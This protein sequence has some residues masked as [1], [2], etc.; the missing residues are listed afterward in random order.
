[1]GGVIEMFVIMLIVAGL[2]FA[3]L[4]YFIYMYTAKGGEPFGETEPH[5]D[6]ESMVLDL[7]EQGISFVK[8][9]IAK[10]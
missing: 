6:S 4:G 2:A 8:G 3:P 9:L 1:M 7:A 10:K 5:G